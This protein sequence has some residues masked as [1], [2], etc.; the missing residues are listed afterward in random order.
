MYII[1]NSLYITFS[2][3]DLYEKCAY[4]H[5][6]IKAFIERKKHKHNT[7]TAD[8]AA[9]TKHIHIA[10]VFAYT[11]QWQTQQISALSTENPEGNDRYK[12]L[13]HHERRII[14]P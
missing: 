11:L 5:T 6:Y 10:R 12:I 7:D 1:Q 9:H 4:N 14:P 2:F 8:T 13:F 3:M